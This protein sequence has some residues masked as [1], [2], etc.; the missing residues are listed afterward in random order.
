MK[1]LI[2]IFGCA[3]ISLLLIYFIFTFIASNRDTKITELEEQYLNEI[4]DNLSLKKDYVQIIP[5]DYVIVKTP[6]GLYYKTNN[7]HIIELWM[8]GVDIKEIPA[9]I[10]YFSELKILKII[11]TNIQS[12]KLVNDLQKIETLNLS[13]NKINKI[14]TINKQEYLKE[15]DLSYNKLS[16]IE[17]LDNLV[18]LEHLNLEGNHISLIENLELSTNEFAFSKK[19]LAVVQQIRLLHNLKTINL[20]NNPIKCDILNMAEIHKLEN[21]SIKIVSDCD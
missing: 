5:K 20:K 3:I 13:Y 8:Y 7:Y 15:L 16:K 1:K 4:I 17:G 2:I 18:S 9:E 21:R 10:S 12:L 6:Y 11:D 19:E 14:D